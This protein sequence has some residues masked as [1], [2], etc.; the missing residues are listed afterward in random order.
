MPVRA[1]PALLV[2]LGAAL[3]V[4]LTAPAPAPAQDKDKDAALVKAAKDAAVANLKKAGIDKPTVVETPG[5]LVAGS[6]SEEKAKALGEALEKTTAVARKALKFDDK[7]APWKGKLTVYFMPDNAEFKAL[8]RRA[9]QVPP[10]GA[11]SALRADP[12]FLVDPAEATGKATD[13]D[14]YFSTAARVAGAHLQGKGTGTQN[15]PDW[16][17]DGFGRVTAMRAEGASSKRYTAYKALAR[18]AVAKGAKLD[19]VWGAEKS[20]AADALGQS[21]AEYLTYGPGAAKF[22]M[23]LDGLKPGENNEAPTIQQALEA[24]GLKEKDKGFA[25]VEA[26]WRK[27]AAGK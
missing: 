24:A 2:A 21:F 12:P 26:A 1:L 6:L 18:G 17:R 19:D 20:P 14:L 9:F 5:Y 23:I 8:M 11:H 25:M 10:E 4:T 13:A 15:L 3:A 27:W 22:P 16:L 7:E